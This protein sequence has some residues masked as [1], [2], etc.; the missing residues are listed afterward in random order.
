MSGFEFLQ[1]E[2]TGDLIRITINRPPF[3]VLEFATLAEM[4]LAMEPFV[5][6]RPMSQ[7]EKCSTMPT[8]DT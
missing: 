4:K 7:I 2:S 6:I 3:N 1:C 8:A 5:E